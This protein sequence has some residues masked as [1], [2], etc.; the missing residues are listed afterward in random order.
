MEEDKNKRLD[1]R[2]DIKY[3]DDYYSDKAFRESYREEHEEEDD[4]LYDEDFMDSLQDDI[5]HLVELIPLL[6]VDLQTAVNQVFKPV[7]N[8]WY[9]N[10]K[11]RL[12]PTRIPDPD[13]PII[14]PTDPGGS[15]D[16]GSGGPGG[17]SSGG[18]PGGGDPGGGGPGG[19]GGP[20][21]D[22]GGGDP[23]T[24]PGGNN[25]RTFDDEET[26]DPK[27][28]VIYTP[29]LQDP[30]IPEPEEV[31]PFEYIGDDDIFA[32]SSPFTIEYEDIDPLEKIEL[33]YTKNVA[34]LYDYYL[35][36]LKNALHKFYLGLINSVYGA[37]KETGAD[38]AKFILEDI[39][40][41]DTNVEGGLRHLIDAALR[42]E[43]TGS[44]K[45]SFCIN[46][47]SIEST[48]YHMKDFKVAKQLRTR[49]EE[50]EMMKDGT[51]D[52]SV[53]D[54]ILQGMRETYDKKYDTSY[55]NLYKYLNSSVDVL[56]DVLRTLMMGVRAK[57]ILIKKGG[58]S[59]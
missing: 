32:P 9:E 49:Y 55:I 34:D 29:S 46:T 52:G 56:D 14:R 23:N 43:V 18:G 50:E 37:N 12:Y 41:A 31:E 22:P 59:E 54:R 5:D 44:L 17:D 2:P 28:P 1:Y 20:S 33:E 4:D 48:L 25:G 27:P 15:S 45:L 30:I 42:G 47:F 3:E 10:L 7:F 13:K 6:P 51:V 36:K 57:E 24:D 58:T 40:L 39:Q 16:G 53:S 8:D 11:G 19:G 38:C 35:T 26:E 21:D